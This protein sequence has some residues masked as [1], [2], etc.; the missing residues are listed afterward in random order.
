MVRVE[1]R[2]YL[3]R[4]YQ[5]LKRQQRTIR[6][7]THST[8]CTTA[9]ASPSHNIWISEPNTEITRF[10]LSIKSIEVFHWILDWRIMYTYLY[11]ICLD[12]QRL[13]WYYCKVNEWENWYHTSILFGHSQISQEYRKVTFFY[14]RTYAT[15]YQ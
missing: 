6:T 13:W 8:D 10:I 1:V 15:V 11:S 2:T 7:R 14:T 12:A 5:N 3:L 4:D 9:F